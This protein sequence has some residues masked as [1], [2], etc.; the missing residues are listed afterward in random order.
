MAQLRHHAG[1]SGFTL[2]ELLVTLFI[3]AL[4]AGTVLVSLPARASDAERYASAL[5]LALH[6]AGREAIVSGEPVAFALRGSSLHRFERYSGGG[7]Q[8]MG[9]GSG[10]LDENAAIHVSVLHAEGARKTARARGERKSAPAR[11]AP[12]YA[13]QLIFAPTGEAT[14][15]IITIRGP[16]GEYRVSI[17]ASGT[18]SQPVSL[19]ER[20]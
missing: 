9:A 8:V 3:I 14:P 12:E 5:S 17:D 20:G 4:M 13:R 10:Q 6:R 15:A 19:T 2:T 1:E 11:A 18:V 7:W 16:R